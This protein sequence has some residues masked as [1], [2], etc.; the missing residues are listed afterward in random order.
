MVANGSLGTLESVVYAPNTTFRVV[1]DSVADILV[2]VPSEPPTAVIVRLQR[3]D[4]ASPILGP[5]D[6]DLFPLFFSTQAFKQCEIALEGTHHGCRRVLSTRIQQFPL[7]C[8]VA[9][10]IYKVQGETLSRM[11]VTEWRSKN[12]AANKREQPYLLVSRVTSRYALLAL[13]PWRPK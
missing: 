11:V 7:V 9:S 10:T 3:G 6:S 4:C 8:A 5:T 13:S 1:H 2:K 12:A